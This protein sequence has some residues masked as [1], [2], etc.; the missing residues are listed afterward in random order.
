MTLDLTA[1]AQRI[2]DLEWAIAHTSSYA[3]CDRME[4]EVNAILEGAH[5]LGVDAA[6]DAEYQRLSR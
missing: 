3:E 1:I 2:I 4:Q 6:L 5:D